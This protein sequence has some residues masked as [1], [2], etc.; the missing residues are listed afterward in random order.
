ML[1]T[2]DERAG[3]AL[4]RRAAPVRPTRLSP[5]GP[6]LGVS[7]PRRRCPSTG[8]QGSI[9]WPTLCSVVPTSS[10]PASCSL[11]RRHSPGSTNTTSSSRSSSSPS[12]KPSVT[13]LSWATSP[14]RPSV[15]STTS[16]L[17]H[18]RLDAEIPVGDLGGTARVE[19]NHIDAQVL[20]AG[21][22]LGDNDTRI[23]SVARSLANEGHDVVLVSKDMPL[24]I[25]AASIGLEAQEYRAELPVDSGWTGMAR[26]ERDLGRRRGT[27]RTRHA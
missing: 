19:L 8:A 3:A 25:K 11:T 14:V 18:G 26:A 6:G 23:L 2:C 12:S 13:T 5:D 7:C 15:T 24:R 17:K 16:G 22:R 1:A 20:P 10:T 9:A 4:C 27:V 21:F